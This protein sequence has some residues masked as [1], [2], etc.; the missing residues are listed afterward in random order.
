ML[1]IDGALKYI[2][3]SCSIIARDGTTE[4]QACVSIASFQYFKQLLDDWRE[5]TL[6]KYPNRP[7][8]HEQILPSTSM[9]PS[10][11][12][13]GMLSTDACPTALLLFP[14][15]IQKIN[16]YCRDDLDISEEEIN[17]ILEGDLW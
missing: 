16:R 4:E 7:D 12:L 5:V 17:P 10:K 11:L 2:C 3:L 8:L 1:D 6:G 14:T 15:L 13:G 9:C